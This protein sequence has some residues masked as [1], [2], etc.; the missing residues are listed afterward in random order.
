MPLLHFQ[1]YELIATDAELV[2]A[3]AALTGRE[4]SEVETAGRFGQH[5]Q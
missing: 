5:L 4:L 2:A 3:I 1:G